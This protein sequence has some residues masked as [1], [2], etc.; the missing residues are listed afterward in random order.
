MA[1]IL[2]EYIKGDR[3][4]PEFIERRRMEYASRLSPVML[5]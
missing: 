1:D 3:F 4:S 2:A 5:V